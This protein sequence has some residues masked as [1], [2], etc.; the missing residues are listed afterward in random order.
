MFALTLYLRRRRKRISMKSSSVAITYCLCLLKIVLVLICLTGTSPHYPSSLRDQGSCLSNSTRHKLW[1]NLSWRLKKSSLIHNTG[2]QDPIYPVNGFVW[3]QV[4]IH[5]SV[6][7]AL[8]LTCGPLGSAVC[9][10]AGQSLCPIQ[11][12]I[13]AMR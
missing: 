4:E 2:P 11:D 13:G 10:A 9:L 5:V 7:P 8:C 1:I 12:L 6:G 3:D